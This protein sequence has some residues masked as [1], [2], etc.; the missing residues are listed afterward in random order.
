MDRQDNRLRAMPL[1]VP[2]EILFGRRRECAAIDNESI[3]DL[4]RLIT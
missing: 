4:V 1:P 3:V 2:P